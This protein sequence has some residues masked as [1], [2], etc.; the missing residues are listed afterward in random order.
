MANDLGILFIGDIFSQPGIETTKKYLPLLKEKYK[1]D[2]VIAQGENISGR[3]GLNL[4]DYKTL[5]SIGIDAFTLGNHAWF[6]SEIHNIINN[7]D[8]IRPANIE[9]DYPGNGSNVFIVNNQKLRIT[10]LMGITF[11]KLL[12]PWK[13]EYANSFFDEIDSILQNDESDYHIIDFH[14]ET[15]SEKNVLALYL[16]GKISACIG[17]H[18][19]VQTNDARILPKGTAFITDAG[20][21][22][23]SN[24][25]IGANFQEVYE[26]MRYDSL[27]RFQVSNNKCQFNGVYLV[28]SNDIKNRKIIP[29]NI[30]ED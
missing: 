7:N 9:K 1:I 20:M 12:P 27:V 14:A 24:S 21:T 8:V 16:D 6:N 10:S 26:K 25:A 29:I 13:E 23:P 2:F 5:K 4:S 18:T 11:N 19:H 15:T 3:K 30:Y 22:G 17:T 28:L